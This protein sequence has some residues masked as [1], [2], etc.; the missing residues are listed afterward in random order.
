M[1]T[2][3]KK[4]I[5]PTPTIVTMCGPSRE[6]GDAVQRA[7]L[8]IARVSDR[9]PEW[10]VGLFGGRREDQPAGADRAADRQ[11]EAVA[12]HEQE[13]E[14]AAE[15]QQPELHEAS[16]EPRRRNVRARSA[17]PVE[18]DVRT[19]NREQRADD[20]GDRRHRPEGGDPRVEPGPSV[21]AGAQERH[22]Q[23]DEAESAGGDDPPIADVPGDGRRREGIAEGGV[24]RDLGLPDDD[25]RPSGKA[26]SG[27]AGEI[28]R[29]SGSRR[30]RRSLRG[31]SSAR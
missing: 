6:R 20:G 24:G 29:P 23:N 27:T 17:R 21:V 26:R 18:V 2:R 7:A 28:R 31:P 19:V 13:A 30:T 1:A 8:E 5:K 16:D 3:P 4:I 12:A 15:Q 22:E 14:H 11:A 25:R 10:C 9:Q